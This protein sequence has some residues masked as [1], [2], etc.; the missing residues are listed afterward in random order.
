MQNKSILIVSTEFPPAPGG[1]GSHAFALAYELE[2]LGWDVTVATE[3]NYAPDYEIII[4]NKSQNFR[5]EQLKPTP[6]AFRLLRKVVFLIRL[7]IKHKP[8]YVCGTGKHGAWFGYLISKICFKK[9]I[10]IGHGTEFTVTMSERSKKI[11]KF[12]YSNAS[13]LVSVSNYTLK[14]I[15][16]VGIKNKNAHVIHNGANPFDFFKLN[17]EEV[18]KIR[19]NNNL[20]DKNVILTIGNVTPR[21]GQEWVI[22]ALPQILEEFPNTHYY[23]IGLPTIKSE[24]ENLASDLKISSNVHFLGRLSTSEINKWTNAADIF[25][26]TSVHNEGDFEGFGISV[27]EAA[28][29]GKT[30][31]VTN[32]S[33]VYESIVDNSTGFGVPER[34]P[35]SIAE[36]IC[37]LL[38]DKDLK[39]KM[40]T[41]ALVRAQGD[42]TWPKVVLKYEKLLL[43]ELDN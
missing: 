34:N 14:T 5:I 15:E 13:I 17:H 43:G 1:I 29:C 30:A 35:S 10:L 21:K 4:F 41:A 20:M 25:A 8:T 2:K 31:I 11:N 24:L 37:L 33:G 39:I 27:I 19:V 38:K 16:N 12:V 40:E 42:F 28:L 36:K 3:Q 32:E 9:S 22:R 26:M 7:T 18:D 6:S 23:C